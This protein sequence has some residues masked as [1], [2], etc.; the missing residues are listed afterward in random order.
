[1]VDDVEEAV[2]GAALHRGSRQMPSSTLCSIA[3]MLLH[4]ALKWRGAYPRLLV[5]LLLLLL[6][7]APE[8]QRLGRVVPRRRRPRFLSLSI[9]IADRSAH[10]PFFVTYSNDF[11]RSVRSS[12]SRQG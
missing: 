8:M 5:V 1:V 3:R 2:R 9:P 11:E 12:R 6:R 7:N 4:W 10:L